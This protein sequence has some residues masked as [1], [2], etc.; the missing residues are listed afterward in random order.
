MDTYNMMQTEAAAAKLR[1]VEHTRGKHP[2]VNMG[3]LMGQGQ[4]EPTL[5]RLGNYAAL[6]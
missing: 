1:M 2:A 4:K 3:I 5:L 6:I